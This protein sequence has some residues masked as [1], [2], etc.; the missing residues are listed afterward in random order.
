MKLT[1]FPEQ[2]LVVAENQPPYTPMPAYYMGTREGH[3]VCCWKLSFRERLSVLLSGR[4]WHQILTFNQPL[5]PQ[6]LS[7]S[8]P[9]MQWKP[10]PSPLSSTPT[11]NLGE[12]ASAAPTSSGADAESHITSDPVPNLNSAESAS[13]SSQLRA[14]SSSSP[15]S[16]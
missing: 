16:P 14:S 10:N 9:S 4:V 6:L 7:I 12:S 1:H 11:P 3:I 2:N 13:F 5:Q 15:D 8:K